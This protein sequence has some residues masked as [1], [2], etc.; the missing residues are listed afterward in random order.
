MK[1]TKT[2]PQMVQFFREIKYLD[3]QG[4]FTIE[5]FTGIAPLYASHL[6]A[7]LEGGYCDIESIDV[8]CEIFTVLLNNGFIDSAC[9]LFEYLHDQVYTKMSPFLQSLLDDEDYAPMLLRTL[10]NELYEINQESEDE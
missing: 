4:K 3:K 6:F 10:V 1:N 7:G 5:F 2:L 8:I 9:C